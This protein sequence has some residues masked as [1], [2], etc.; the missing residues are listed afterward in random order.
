MKFNLFYNL[1]ELAKRHTIVILSGVFCIVVDQ[2]FKYVAQTSQDHAFYLIPHLVGWEY[3]ENPGIAFGIPVPQSIIIP[4]TLLIVIIALLFLKKKS[5]T[6]QKFL[7]V[8]LITAGAIS[9]LIDRVL[10]GFT[11]DYI[12][13]ITSILNIADILIIL[14]AFLLIR[15][16]KKTK[17]MEG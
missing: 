11:I 5:I 7:G 1:R 13:I 10:Y 3:F 15:E 14:G 16:N 6:R 12:R 8:I 9:N 17:K 4:L 2:T